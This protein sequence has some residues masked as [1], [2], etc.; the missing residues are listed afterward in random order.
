MFKILWNISENSSNSQ[1]YWWKNKD[2]SEI[3]TYI[4][5]YMCVCVCIYIYIYSMVQTMNLNLGSYIICSESPAGIY[6]FKFNNWKTRKMCEICS[7]LIIKI[8][9][10]RIVTSFWCFYCKLWINV[11]YCSG[12]SI[13]DFEQ[14]NTGE[15][16][17]PAFHTKSSNHKARISKQF[18]LTYI[19]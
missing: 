12:V 18:W 1:E 14:V 7:K 10:R 19:S 9:G 13:V 5:I 3:Y 4:Y 2:K 16:V 15:T 11:K 6:L 17:A 8:T